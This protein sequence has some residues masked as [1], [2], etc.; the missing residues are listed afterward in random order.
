[1]IC[2]KKMQELTDFIKKPNLKIVGIEKAKRIHNIFNK[3]ITENFP[4]LEKTMPIHVR[5]ASRTQKRHEE[6][7]TT[8]DI[9]SLKQQ[10]QRLEKEY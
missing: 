3:I 5:E 9:L 6:N 2:E 1:M 8:H 4:N 10:V 7:R